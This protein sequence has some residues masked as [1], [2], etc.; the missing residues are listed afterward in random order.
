MDK[1]LMAGGMVEHIRADGFHFRPQRTV[2]WLVCD[3]V[4]QPARIATLVGDWAAG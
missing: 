3:M 1:A 2:D 4:E